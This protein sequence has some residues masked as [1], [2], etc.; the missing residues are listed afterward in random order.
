MNKQVKMLIPL[1]LVILFCFIDI[2]YYLKAI[3]PAKKQ[4][5]TLSSQLAHVND[6]SEKVHSEKHLSADDLKKV[7]QWQTVLPWD[8]SVDQF[9]L[10]LQKAEVSSG[11]TIVQY[12]LADD[13]NSSTNTTD[14]TNQA[15]QTT[16]TNFNPTSFNTNESTNTT[17]TDSKQ[18]NTAKT[19]LPSG[20]KQEKINLVVQASTYPEFYLFLK[21]L[22]QMDRV[23]RVESI[24]FVGNNE[25]ITTENEANPLTV[26]MTISI[27]YDPAIAK[28]L[29]LALPSISVPDAA[30]KSNPL[31]PVTP[32]I[33]SMENNQNNSDTTDHTQTSENRQNQTTDTNH[34]STSENSH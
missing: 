24:Q 27:Y 17:N 19:S 21:Q 9:I 22:E 30:G 10:D 6:S 14:D 1:I 31:V 18:S 34:T 3:V 32:T 15:N 11:C 28:K 25:P 23:N 29:H 7:Y 12:E 20:V 2:F 33:K 16:G 4:I 13:S 5:A 8:D 26:N